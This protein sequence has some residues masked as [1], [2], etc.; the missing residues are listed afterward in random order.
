MIPME[1]ILEGCGIYLKDKVLVSNLG[2]GQKSQDKMCGV[3][4]MRLIKVTPREGK[5]I[6]QFPNNIKKQQ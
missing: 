5:V 3:T 4:K 2:N 1:D 6:R